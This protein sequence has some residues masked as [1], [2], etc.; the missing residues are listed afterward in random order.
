MGKRKNSIAV[1]DMSKVLYSG[2]SSQEARRLVY[3]AF[4]EL[5]ATSWRDVE[6]IILNDDNISLDDLDGLDTFIAQTATCQAISLVTPQAVIGVRKL[7]DQRFLDALRQNQSLHELDGRLLA[8]MMEHDYDVWRRFPREQPQRQQQPLH[9]L[10]S[11]HPGDDDDES[12]K[13]KPTATHQIFLRHSTGLEVDDEDLYQSPRRADPSKANDMDETYMVTEPR[14]NNGIEDEGIDC[15][16][17]PSQDQQSFMSKTF[18]GD[19]NR[20]K[21]IIITGVFSFNVQWLDDMTEDDVKSMME[22]M[23]LQNKL[24]QFVVCLGDV[25]YANLDGLTTPAD[26]LPS[27]PP[28]PP[29]SIQRIIQILD[30]LQKSQTQKL[31][32][33]FGTDFCQPKDGRQGR[34]TNEIDNVISSLCNLLCQSK[35][36]KDVQLTLYDALSLQQERKITH[37][38]TYQDHD[39]K[40]LKIKYHMSTNRQSDLQKS[41]DESLQLKR[42]HRVAMEAKRAA[43][44]HL[45]LIELQRDPYTTM[46]MVQSCCV[47]QEEEERMCV[48]LHQTAT[49]SQWE[50]E[51]TKPNTPLYHAI[52]ND[53]KSSHAVCSDCYFELLNRHG[54]GELRCP[55]GC[56]EPAHLPAPKVLSSIPALKTDQKRRQ[57]CRSGFNCR[58]KAC[59]HFD[60]MTLPFLTHLGWASKIH[61]CLKTIFGAKFTVGNATYSNLL[62]RSLA[63]AMEQRYQESDL[64]YFDLIPD[65]PNN[66][67]SLFTIEQSQQNGDNLPPVSK[68]CF[69]FLVLM[70]LLSSYVKSDNS[71]TRIDWDMGIVFKVNPASDPKKLK[72]EEDHAVFR[73]IQCRDKLPQGSLLLPRLRWMQFLHYNNTSLLYSLLRP[74]PDVYFASLNNDSVPQPLVPSRNLS[75]LQWRPC[76]TLGHNKANQDIVDELNAVLERV[77]QVRL[78]EKTI[79]FDE[80]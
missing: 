59:I 50:A 6:K 74:N 70:L 51:R 3:G 30:M 11:S 32:I 72:T 34:A 77:S 43:D 66:I 4:F 25:S 67:Y 26:T 41:V 38:L 35:S 62:H 42:E 8:S 75:E 22:W 48:L 54:T 60:K 23:S 31:H 45:H 44:I 69:N 71:G 1:L 61:K 10:E 17:D 21:N 13:Y 49:I 18:A 15:A 47:C 55:M 19:Q 65:S 80:R 2:E 58:N 46:A 28:P 29:P 14:A 53:P 9:N 52:K 76:V 79:T 36:L 68:E 12:E 40:H 78:C 63:E 37:M 57:K 20:L 64:W 16:S 5:L 24:R 56:G 27:P 33:V 73:H 7:S 39:V